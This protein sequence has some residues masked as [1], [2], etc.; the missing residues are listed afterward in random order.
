MLM[1]VAD[2]LGGH[3]HGE[4]AAQVAVQHFGAA[5]RREARPTLADPAQFLAHTMAG[6][7][8]AILREAEMRELADTPR[9]VLVAC[10]VQEGY[11]HWMHIGD[12]RLYFIRDGRVMLRTRDHTVV[13]QLLDAGRIPEEAA[14]SHP[15]RNR[16]LQ[17]LGGYEAPQ[18]GAAASACLAKNDVL[19]LCSDGLWGP[20]SQRELLHALLTRELKEA[21]AQLVSLAERS[22]GPECDNVTAL[23]I[24]WREDEAP[25]A[26]K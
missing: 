23:A 1:V 14:A 8:A 9:T 21:V 24:A 26:G 15:A 20:L 22:A 16:L 2:G 11:A 25:S 6:S 5:F 19:L 12:C 3:P 17:C 18:P 7:H 10:V 13:Q 4:I